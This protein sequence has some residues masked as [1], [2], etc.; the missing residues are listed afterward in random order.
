MN[1]YNLSRRLVACAAVMAFSAGSAM[2]H[3]EAA[4]GD[5][6]EHLDA[7]CKAEPQKCAD[8]KKRIEDERAAC[9]QDPQACEKK[10]EE[11]RTKFDEARKAHREKCDKDPEACKKERDALRQ[12]LDERCKA[13][14]QKCE[15]GKH[16]HGHEH[17]P[18]PMH[19]PKEAPPPVP[20]AR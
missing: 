20:P 7:H 1:I 6:H 4:R 2:A 15:A 8:I 12:K 10:R 9:K 14:P 11:L 13:E 18:A 16:R 19:P 17:G 3:P 5:M